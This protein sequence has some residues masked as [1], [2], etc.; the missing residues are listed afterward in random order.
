M[1]QG[2]STSQVSVRGQQVAHS[3]SPQMQSKLALHALPPSD[4]I[5][6]I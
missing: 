6:V 1:L 5:H 2:S 3:V 4:T